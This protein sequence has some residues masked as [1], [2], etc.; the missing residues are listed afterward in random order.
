MCG[1]RFFRGVANPR[2]WKASL[3][4]VPFRSHQHTMPPHDGVRR[5]DRNDVLQS[6]PSK[7]LPF[8]GRSLALVIV[9]NDPLFA[10]LLPK[11]LIFST[12]IVNDLLLFSVHDAGQDGEQQV[13]RL[14]DMICHRFDLFGKKLLRL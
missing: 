5:Y 10:D 8:N 14:K 9:E 3:L 13:P 12:E 6:L 2:G 7:N 1:G 4:I 11:D